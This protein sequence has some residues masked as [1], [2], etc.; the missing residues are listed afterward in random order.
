[1]KLSSEGLV[2]SATPDGG[3][4]IMSSKLQGV[5]AFVKLSWRPRFRLRTKAKPRQGERV[6]RRL[7]SLLFINLITTGHV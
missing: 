3:L 5:N 4:L 6:S 2:E 1:M 7:K